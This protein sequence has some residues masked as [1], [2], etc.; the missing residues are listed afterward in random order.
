MAIEIR[1]AKVSDSMEVATVVCWLK[2][3]G[4]RVVAGEVIAELETEKA[5]V[6]LEAPAS[7]TLVRILVPDG[8][9][10]V[11]VGAL[12]AVIEPPGSKEI[13]EAPRS[14]TEDQRSL[15][16]TQRSPLEIQRQS[17]KPPDMT[18]MVRGKT[19]TSD[20]EP[21]VVKQQADAS[22]KATPLARM[23][24]QLAGLE[25]GALATG[26]PAV[27][28]RTQVEDALGLRRTPS[29]GETA[30][31]HDASD[32]SPPAR[33]VPHNAIRKIIA[34]RMTEAKQ[35]IPHFYLSIECVPTSATN[36]L[37]RLNREAFQPRLTLTSLVVKAVATAIDRVPVVNAEWTP[38]H[39]ALRKVNIAFGVA[40]SSGL[41]APVI[42]N[43][44]S[45][46]LLELAE[47]MEDLIGR[48]KNARLRPQDTTGGT[49]TVSNLGMFGVSS[50]FA[51]VTPGQSCVLGIGASR[52]C[53]VIRDGRL[54]V[55]KLMT[56][57]LSA[58]H[59]ALDGA[60][61]AEFLGVFKEL[62]EEPARM[63]L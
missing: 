29:K 61:G 43:A 37:E 53:P 21:I 44:D 62:I 34:G 13:G 36:F 49:F 55:G 63:I 47:E 15:A 24:A 3:A 1:L 54:A 10:N 7:G 20:N 8:T 51:I 26:T 9:E 25:L 30:R 33:L 32:E 18:G 39:L 50:L 52:D 60:Q 41:V 2:R 48:A 17:A 56:A 16:E 59:R 12:L 35:K 5:G 23:M 45:K 31:S 46:T 58:D 28:T 57:T 40:T 22:V 27:V 4:D 42:R 11:Q 19:E 14:S 38:S 6:E